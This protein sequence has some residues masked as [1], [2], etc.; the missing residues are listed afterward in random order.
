MLVESVDASAET[1]WLGAVV[2]PGGGGADEPT[3]RT[4]VLKVGSCDGD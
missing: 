4:D 1:C 3:G 2:V